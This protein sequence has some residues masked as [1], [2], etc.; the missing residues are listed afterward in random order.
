MPTR[1]SAGPFDA[2]FQCPHGLASLYDPQQLDE[3]GSQ[4]A[5]VAGCCPPLRH[6]LGIH[7]V[8]VA[9]FALS[10]T[11]GTREWTGKA[12]NTR[13]CTTSIPKPR[14]LREGCKVERETRIGAPATKHNVEF[15]Y[16]LATDTWQGVR[17][18]Y[19]LP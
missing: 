14:Y 4:R 5:P 15:I 9:H 6:L 13:I 1:R 16:R 8:V 3:V 17:V 11:L 7:L 19:C 18:G 12:T 2:V 10:L